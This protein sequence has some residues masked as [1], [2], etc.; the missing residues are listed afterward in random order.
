MGGI[1]MCGLI[2]I[3]GVANHNTGQQIQTFLCSYIK[4]DVFLFYD[5]LNKIYVFFHL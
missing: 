4:L 3:T 2:V 5:S 1:L